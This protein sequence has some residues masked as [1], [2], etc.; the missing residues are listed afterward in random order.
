MNSAV[1][2]ASIFKSAICRTN[3][4]PRPNPTLFYYPGLN[5]CEPIIPKSNFPVMTKLLQDNY[6]IIRQEYENLKID[7]FKN[8][9]DS[10]DHKLHQGNWDWHSCKT[11][12]VLAYTFVFISSN[13]L[14]I[15]LV[16]RFA[17]GEATS[18]ICCQMSSY[19]GDFRVNGEP[20]THAEYSF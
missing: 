6:A 5:N 8:D 9:Y 12:L 14:G 19:C 15:L 10:G 2:N 7:G 11:L 4:R 3:C 18:R 1:L 16:C 13:L 20:W 17:K